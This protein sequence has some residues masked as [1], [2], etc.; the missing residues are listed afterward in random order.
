MGIAKKDEKTQK[1]LICA[2]IQSF[3]TNK[4]NDKKLF[5]LFEFQFQL[6]DAKIES[7]T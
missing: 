2:I 1:V 6:C 7:E 3:K 4:D 5:S